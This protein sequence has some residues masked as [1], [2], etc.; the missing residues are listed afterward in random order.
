M[1]SHITIIV[2]N[3]IALPAL[4]RH[5]SLVH[6]SQQ[7]VFL[8]GFESFII[9]QHELEEEVRDYE[10][11]EHNNETLTRLKNIVHNS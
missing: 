8:K 3:R 5:K 1:R 7:H 11:Q 4:K 9:K 6:I 2:L 10:K